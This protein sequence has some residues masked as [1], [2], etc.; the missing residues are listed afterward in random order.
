MTLRRVRA[1]MGGA[2]AAGGAG[3]RARR[4]RAWCAVAQSVRRVAPCSAVDSLRCAW[5]LRVDPTRLRVVSSAEWPRPGRPG[6]GW[7]RKVNPEGP[8]VVRSVP[9]QCKAVREAWTGEAGPGRTGSGLE[10]VGSQHLRRMSEHI[11]AAETH[12]GPARMNVPKYLLRHRRDG[13]CGTAGIS[14]PPPGRTTLSVP[15]GSTAGRI[16]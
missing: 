2:G 12:Y 9:A 3:I 16:E 14:L 15:V 7:T 1:G 5:R 10:A 8:C 4:H 13:T 6:L 11:R